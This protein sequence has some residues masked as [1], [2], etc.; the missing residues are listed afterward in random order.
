MNQKL[1]E[2]IKHISNLSIE[3]ER[4]EILT[5]FIAYLQSKLS[6]KEPISINF[7]C[8]H[9]SRRSHLG[10]VWMQ[11]LAKYFNIESITTYS[12]GTEVL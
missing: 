10:Q 6:K 11:T 5:L 9:N 7:I 3:D 1:T 4:K 2:T 12:G 8:T